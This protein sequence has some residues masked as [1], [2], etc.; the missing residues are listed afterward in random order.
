RNKLDKL[1]T[2]KNKLNILGFGGDTGLYEK[3]VANYL[4][5]NKYCKEANIFIIDPFNKQISEGICNLNESILKGEQNINFDLIFCRFVLHHV[6]PC[7]RWS[8]FCHLANKLDKCGLLLM[9]EE[10]DF[11][12]EVYSLQQMFYQFS[13]MTI[14]LIINMGLR[15]EW[16]YSSY[17]AIG[18]NFYL[19]YLTYSDLSSIEKEFKFNF[20]KFSFTIGDE[21]LFP[22]TLLVY[23]KINI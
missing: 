4:I 6:E 12:Q 16:F 13:L 15:S 17:P 2:P 5:E 3:N 1:L 19:N 18:E 23:K 9:L 22:L 10:G 8:S 14:D 21:F 11:S 20:E 7:A